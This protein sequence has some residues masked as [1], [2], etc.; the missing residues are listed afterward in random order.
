M[1]VF[2]YLTIEY[3]NG[4]FKTTINCHNKIVKTIKVK[5]KNEEDQFQNGG[6]L[7]S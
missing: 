3:E 1:C 5:F 2:V 7:K 6:Y 4:L